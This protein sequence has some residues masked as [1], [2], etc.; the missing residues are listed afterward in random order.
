MTQNRQVAGF[1]L[2][3]VMVALTIIS[4]GI[5]GT[6]SMIGANRALMS[7]T[8]DMSRMNMIADGVMN[9]LAV[10]A[11]RGE[12]M[13]ALGVYDWSDDPAGVSILFTDNGY[14]ANASTLT[15]SA[16]ILPG[17]LADAT[18][19]IRSPTGRTMT[20]R[21]SFFGRLKTP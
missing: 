9:E 7:S 5:I 2:I 19:Q 20:R 15:L 8:W 18:L 14:R 21:R 11:H 6:L 4:A 3:E 17:G 1:S 16:N 13:P 10:R 12:A